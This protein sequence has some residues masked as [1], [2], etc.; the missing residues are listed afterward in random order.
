MT[1]ESTFEDIYNRRIRPDDLRGAHDA[2]HPADAANA[3]SAAAHSAP[4]PRS[5][6]PGEADVETV[7]RAR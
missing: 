6:A 3:A 7:V 5:V 2:H 4:N 1:E